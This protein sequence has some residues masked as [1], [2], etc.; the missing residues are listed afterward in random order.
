MLGVVV[1]CS[2]RDEEVLVVGRVG[3]AYGGGTLM[4]N[5]AAFGAAVF[6]ASIIIVGIIGATDGFDGRNVPVA[7]M[8]VMGSGVAGI[9]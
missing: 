7:G 4:D 8:V 5:G 2:G 3:G 1:V 6:G 9:G